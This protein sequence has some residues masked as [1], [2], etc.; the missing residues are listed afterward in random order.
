[1]HP[2]HPRQFEMIQNAALS[3]FRDQIKSDFHVDLVKQRVN[4]DV[5]IE[6]HH[7]ENGHKFFFSLTG[8]CQFEGTVTM[9]DDGLIDVHMQ[10]QHRLPHVIRHLDS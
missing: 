9:F 3:A 2:K 8:D 4:V 10:K 7:L 6:S 1:M 5:H